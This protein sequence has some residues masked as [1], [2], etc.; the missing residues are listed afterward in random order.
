[1]TAIRSIETIPRTNDTQAKKPIPRT[2]NT[3]CTIT[4]RTGQPNRGSGRDTPA[5]S[6]RAPLEAYDEIQIQYG[7][8]NLRGGEVV[9][10]IAVGRDSSARPIGSRARPK[11]L[12]QKN[13][14]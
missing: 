8:R 5:R 3:C 11:I 7:G 12:A 13:I 9:G 2:C 10:I 1:L 14:L 4:R 6:A